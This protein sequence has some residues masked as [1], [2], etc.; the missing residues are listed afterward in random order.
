MDVYSELADGEAEG[1]VGNHSST[2]EIESAYLRYILISVPNPS[3]NADYFPLLAG[4]RARCADAR[5]GVGQLAKGGMDYG[6]M[7]EGVLDDGSSSKTEDSLLMAYY[8]GTVHQ[9]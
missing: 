8:L 3:G 9:T 4:Q 2:G 6:L 5:G 7:D 1:R